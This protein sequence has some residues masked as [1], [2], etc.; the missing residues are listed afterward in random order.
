VRD[1][2]V[3]GRL[4][5]T[6]NYCCFHSTIL[7]WE[8]SAIIPYSDITNISKEKTVKII[9]NAISVHCNLNKY[10]FTSFTAR[11]RALNIFTQLWKIKLQKMDQNDQTHNESGETNETNE[12][13]ITDDPNHIERI[14]NHSQN[15][16]ENEMEAPQL[17]EEEK[18]SKVFLDAEFPVP[19]DTLFSLL[20]LPSSPFWMAFMNIRKT[21]S[22]SCQDWKNEADKITREAKCLQ[23]RD[24]INI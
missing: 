8:T 2:L 13:D 21:K 1:I 24:S 4:Y 22:W 11:D 20:W 19:V 17:Y 6:E 7:R 15:S 10:I 9:P 3:Q 18:G 14:S 12:L 16:E 5:L 23:V